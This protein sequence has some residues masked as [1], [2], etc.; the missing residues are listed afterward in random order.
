[1]E[2]A[3][4]P[5]YFIEFWLYTINKCTFYISIETSLDR[6][7]YW[8]E[9]VKQIYESDKIAEEKLFYENDFKVFIDVLVRVLYACPDGKSVHI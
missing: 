3:N 7:L 9:K 2:F 6:Q 1:M 8:I 5:Y 4:D